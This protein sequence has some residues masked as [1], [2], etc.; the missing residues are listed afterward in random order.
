MSDNKIIL[1]LKKKLVIIIPI[2]V[3]ILITIFSS[4]KII[5]Q[6]EVGVVRIFGKVQDDEL[7][8]GFNLIIP[9]ITNVIKIPV[10]E[11]TIEMIGDNAIK[12]LTNEGLEVKYDLAIQFIIIPSKASEV[13]SN[14]KDYNVWMA[15]R[16]RG[17]GRD[18]IAEFKAEDLYTSK[19]NQIQDDMFNK[20]ASQFEVH[21]ISMKA[22]IIRNI[23]LPKSVVERIEAKISAKQEAE[24]MEYVI[25]KEE[26]E[27]ERKI[28]EADGISKA[29]KIISESL[30]DKYLS[31]YWIQNLDK[32]SDV[33]YV[34]IGNNGMPLFKQVGK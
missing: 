7:M 29:N 21:G 24:K 9:F 5:E 6:T 25:Q 3:L 14:L 15:S 22:V 27:A 1:K 20:L 10:Y 26:L 12:S 30:S 13:Y 18:I 32:H 8:P 16:V 17:I 23:D 19:R 33:I 31:W 11:Q 4:I 34:P 28:I 2:A